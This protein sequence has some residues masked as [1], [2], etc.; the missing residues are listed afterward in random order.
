MST[1]IFDFFFIRLDKNLGSRKGSRT[2]N[3]GNYLELQV[4]TQIEYVP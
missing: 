1:L 3:S 2:G 4:L